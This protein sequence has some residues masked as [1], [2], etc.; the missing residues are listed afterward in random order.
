MKKPFWLNVPEEPPWA[1]IGAQ[2][3]RP[4]GPSINPRTGFIDD[5]RNFA[6][7]E[8][9]YN[10]PFAGADAIWQTREARNFAAR[11]ASQLGIDIY[12]TRSMLEEMYG[13]TAY[14]TQ[15]GG[16][17]VSRFGQIAVGQKPMWQQTF[18]ELAAFTRQRM[19]D[20]YNVVSA[21]VNPL[22]GQRDVSPA[23]DPWS[24]RHSTPQRQ[25]VISSGQQILYGQELGTTAFQSGPMTFET[26]LLAHVPGFAVEGGMV[27]T[28]ATAGK[29]AKRFKQP[30][31]RG[32]EQ[33]RFKNLP[34]QQHP[35]A[36]QAG[37]AASYNVIPTV[38]FLGKGYF[39]SG[40]SFLDP[41]I[42]GPTEQLKK[43]S[44]TLPPE[45]AEDWE[46]NLVPGQRIETRSGGAFD[47]GGGIS[48][49]ISAAQ[50]VTPVTWGFTE[51][52]ET[53]PTGEQRRVGRKLVG[54]AQVEY[55]GVHG[56]KTLG[57][58]TGAANVPN[59]AQV[60][61]L[62]SE[63]QPLT[64]IAHITELNEM[65][66]ASYAFT[67][68]WTPEQFMQVTGK[69]RW[70]MGSAQKIIR[71]LE[72]TK[73]I[74]MV[75][76][77]MPMYLGPA[78]SDELEPQLAALVQAGAATIDKENVRIDA[79][80]RF[81]DVTI[82]GPAYIGPMANLP[83]MNWP[84]KSQQV[85][86]EELAKLRKVDPERAAAIERYSESYNQM[87]GKIYGAEL[88]TS[89]E[90][91]YYQVVQGREITDR[92]AELAVVAQQ[93]SQEEV[94]FELR[95]GVENYGFSAHLLRAASE[96]SGGAG[97]AINPQ[98][99]GLEGES[100]IMPD[101]GALL[102]M[103]GGGDV[104]DQL[105]GL[106]RS[107]ANIL[108]SL[109]NITMGT[110]GEKERERAQFNINKF[111]KQM[112][113]AT[114]SAEARRR[115]QSNVEPRI[116]GQIQAAQWLAPAEVFLPEQR[117]T[118]LLGKAWGS[119]DFGTAELAKKYKTPEAAARAIM[120]GEA[121]MPDLFAKRM[122]IT[123]HTQLDTRVRA[124]NL[125]DLQW[126]LG[127]DIGLEEANQLGTLM[128]PQVAQKLMG[129]WDIDVMEIGLGTGISDMSQSYLN[130]LM[131]DAA[132]SNVGGELDAI[133]GDIESAPRT[134]GEATEK[135]IAS[136]TKMPIEDVAKASQEFEANKDV[137]G[138]AFNFGQRAIEMLI[139][140]G[141][142][143]PEQL[144]ERRRIANMVEHEMGAPLYMLAQDATALPPE[145]KRMMDMLSY[146]V[147]TQGIYKKGGGGKPGRL[148]M[149]G[150]LTNA[151]VQALKMGQ[152]LGMSSEAV[153]GLLLDPSAEGF[154]DI[155]QI[156]GEGGRQ[157][158]GKAIAKLT[159]LARA[160]GATGEGIY[161]D[162]I[163][164]S[165]L[166]KLG[167]MYG[168]YKAY[169]KRE[170][171]QPG[172]GAEYVS[173]LNP[174]QRR[175]F[176]GGKAI[177]EYTA[178]LS[179]YEGGKQIPLAGFVQTMKSLVAQGLATP[180]QR[181]IFEKAME[182][183]GGAP[184][185][186][187]VRSQ[188]QVSTVGGVTAT[189]RIAEQLFTA[190][191]KDLGATT[192]VAEMAAK[193]FTDDTIRRIT[194][195]GRIKITNKPSDTVGSAIYAESAINLSD[196]LVGSTRNAVG[197]HELGHHVVGREGP[198]IDQLKKM[199]S[200]INLTDTQVD[201]LL[202][203]YDKSKLEKLTLAEKRELAYNR[204][205]IETGADMFAV[206]V[207]G[208]DVA[209]KII[210][211]RWQLFNLEQSGAIEERTGA[212]QKHLLNLMEWE[213]YPEE[214]LSVV[215]EA[216]K[217]KTG[218]RYGHTDPWTHK[219]VAE[220]A[221][222][223][224]SAQNLGD[225]MTVEQIEAFG[226]TEAANTPAT[227]T[228]TVSTIGA[229]GGGRG[230]TGGGVVAA[231]AGGGG[232][233]NNDWKKRK[234]Q[235]A[236]EIK[237]FVS[238]KT[239]KRVVSST[240]GIEVKAKYRA[241]MDEEAVKR[242]NM[243]MDAPGSDKIIE[244]ARK[245]A[246]GG[247]PETR[248]EYDL[249]TKAKALIN[250]VA[251]VS[252]GVQNMSTFYRTSFMEA[253]HI[254][255]QMP[256][257]Q[258]AA[259]M[260]EIEGVLGPYSEQAIMGAPALA[261]VVGLVEEIGIEASETDQWK[262]KYDTSRLGAQLS[263]VARLSKS[264]RNVAKMERGWQYADVLRGM[265][266]G[267]LQFGGRDEAEQYAVSQGLSDKQIDAVAR[268]AG[269]EGL[270]N[271]QRY[272]AMRADPGLAQYLSGAKQAGNYEKELQEVTKSLIEARKD[273]AQNTKGMSKTEKEALDSILVGKAKT[274]SSRI[275]GA[276]YA[277]E[278]V[279]GQARVMGGDA[280]RGFLKQTDERFQPDALAYG[281]KSLFSPFSPAGSMIR[282]V[283]RMGV[284]GADENADRAAQV[285]MAQLRGAAVTG[286]MADMGDT[287]PMGDVIR[288]QNAIADS[289]VRGA[290]AFEQAWGWTRGQGG[291]ATMKSIFGPGIAAGFGA[292]LGLSHLAGV[293]GMG[294][295][296]TFLGAAAAPIGAAVGIGGMLLGA[297]N[298]AIN[299]SEG[300]AYNQMVAAQEQDVLAKGSD[301]SLF[302]KISA[303]VS[304]QLRDWGGGGPSAAR[305]LLGDV[306]N[307]VP[308]GGKT[309]AELAAIAEN[310]LTR[311]YSDLSYA[312]RAASKGLVSSRLRARNEVL[313]LYSDVD[314]QSG[315]DEMYAY[316]GIDTHQIN[317]S[318]EY[319]N[320][321]AGAMT[322][323]VNWQ[324]AQQSA[325]QL[326]MGTQGTYSMATTLAT[327]GTYE[328]NQLMRAYG[329]MSGLRQ[330][331]WMSQDI[332]NLAGAT[333]ELYGT[334][335]LSMQ[336]I[337]G[338]DRR[339]I[340]KYASGQWQTGLEAQGFNFSGQAWAQSYDDLGFQ[341]GTTGG[342]RTLQRGT[343]QDFWN[344]IKDNP[345]ATQMAGGRSMRSALHSTFGSGS[346][347]DQWG[348]QSMMELQ[349]LYSNVQLG[350]SNFQQGWERRNFAFQYGNVALATPTA[351]QVAS[352]TWQ[353]QELTSI[354][355]VGGMYQQQRQIQLAQT[356]LSRTT[357]AGGTYNGI[358]FTG[359]FGFQAEGMANQY[360]QFM[361][362]WQLQGQQMQLNR[363]WQLQ[364]FDWQQQDML[365]GRSRSLIQR[366]WQST[367]LDVGF[368]RAN[369]RFDWQEQDLLRQ[370]EQTER[371]NEYDLW[372]MGWQQRVTGMQRGWQEED[373]EWSSQQRQQSYGW[374]LEDINENIR[375][376]S[377]RQRKQ[378]LKQ[379]ERMTITQTQ[380]E[381]RADTEEERA[382]EMW[383][384]EDERFQKQMERF[385]EE[386]SLQDE[387]WEI[388][389]ER[390]QTQRQWTEDDYNR[391]RER[392]NEK[393]QWEDEDYN[394]QTE[395]FQATVEYQNQVFELQKRNYDMSL[396][397]FQQDFELRQRQFQENVVAYQ[398][399]LKLED[400][401]RRIKEDTDLEEIERARQMLALQQQIAQT[402]NVMDSASHMF[403]LMSDAQSAMF[404]DRLIAFLDKIRQVGSSV[405]YP[406]L[407][408]PY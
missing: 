305:G 263:G 331:G 333:G 109:G 363:G 141:G 39:P 276:A 118:E 279:S 255:A 97:I 281:V 311:K 91:P 23:D 400:E 223:P 239:V 225:L 157:A 364:G 63:G 325:L 351:Q 212:L 222:T 229:G 171:D 93:R 241:G 10:D 238:G 290:Y 334:A 5:P 120:M 246:T 232:G 159:E 201:K 47:L 310:N 374:N 147:E 166:L 122:P 295:L 87:T 216:V 371:G 404:M 394:R 210:E 209:G 26:E 71:H 18:D 140:G 381:E 388:Q 57:E 95:E 142:G 406:N 407:N 385:D 398:E 235:L 273:L 242:I 172:S 12:Q 3:N 117:M 289:K 70:S 22:T 133:I 408:T 217:K 44:V 369:I 205:A 9:M 373:W 131:Q 75:S 185:G 318:T 60:F 121:Q 341:I 213:E 262:D 284:G 150:F 106:P 53:M 291:G 28:G 78:G 98:E 170:R 377:G 227:S 319:E 296:G 275:L 107:A 111:R 132:V 50:A 324:G 130:M 188:A 402:K 267:N 179:R 124:L 169:E 37:A 190:V 162:V 43:F 25:T 42:T 353:P 355:Q 160:R 359:N 143:S 367:D 13:P 105:F 116:G 283:W 215:R 145:A 270:T 51:A 156:V 346:I 269:K 245:V 49:Q 183:V 61:N 395:R 74:R 94:P 90:A 313:G 357:Q 266:E 336:R 38:A 259:Y 180:E 176:E 14:H 48:T 389:F 21:N 328:Q 271:A 299:A 4:L 165:P 390:L 85:S 274:E 249:M 11:A 54:Q 332:Q 81:G 55:G 178:A 387:N 155:T 102:R 350:A 293:S 154:A 219:N 158:P 300:T 137:M 138:P 69:E 100:F 250:D 125:K 41:V 378:L 146:N 342:L 393:N 247:Q 126:R 59:M 345:L 372:N 191:E 197:F 288:R 89:G 153:A 233:G 240:G 370:K 207:G 56:I 403:Q 24:F 307:L 168:H 361:Q 303:T 399:Q 68:E 264:A 254:A 112:A 186:K 27:E 103:Y 196:E 80:S 326:G 82:T 356:A 206:A 208:K 236:Y 62:Q 96:I 252:S 211:D 335:E 163:E 110:G 67:M 268:V 221:S 161:Q 379:R 45:L 52:Y 88:A 248:E 224:I 31:G 382:R 195:S 343:S 167:E 134:I 315:L 203:G 391:D 152:A 309:T 58:K 321:L 365:T 72:E 298:Y 220:M 46:P 184:G 327:K 92:A 86:A 64:G 128:A 218:V 40:Q 360:N 20:P 392:M 198:L 314:V 316:T 304:G 136:I 344:V 2:S 104:E 366:G 230:P 358:Q 231:A 405:G 101:P 265:Y 127:K 320:M 317:R 108:E 338:G 204:A 226:K 8:E 79:G 149:G 237:R 16:Q 34:Y 312:E 173:K 272:E 113:F 65:A 129:D 35:I 322:G 306:F 192:T 189:E 362:N 187:P 15:V 323:N 292:A 73:Q 228:P 32:G 278:G 177:R 256:E 194:G 214:T 144:D 397:H 297:T 286:G 76:A 234:E 114:G 348:G 401:L 384:M 181:E 151:T 29:V 1:E 380:G 33:T 396:E 257:D 386:R 261:G 36:P 115:L 251:K 301:A 308:E 339:A 199:Y 17:F 294:A 139:M 368:E 337:L 349:Q 354:E 340:S 200:G 352:G 376:A 287:G 253:E 99:Y 302:S 175:M 30:A 193:D 6:S 330:Y 375:F 282:A 202:H 83:R 148:G 182:D 135:A 123:E 277:A 84:Y 164:R 383:R 347:A 77:T 66:Q 7:E 244:L 280:Y 19:P 174:F 119:Q 243:V 285:G 258:R 260:K 329:Q